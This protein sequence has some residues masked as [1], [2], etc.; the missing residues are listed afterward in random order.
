MAPQEAPTQTRPLV[1][2]PN[3]VLPDSSIYSQNFGPG[4][5]PGSTALYTQDLRLFIFYPRWSAGNYILTAT[6]NDWHQG[7]INED[8]APSSTFLFGSAQGATTVTLS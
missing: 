2:T 4:T 1:Y 8:T 3:C 5:A 7:T 6:V